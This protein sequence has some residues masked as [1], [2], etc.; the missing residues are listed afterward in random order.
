MLRWVTLA[1][2]TVALLMMSLLV[3]PT[4]ALLATVPA[5]IAGFR[6]TSFAALVA[7]ALLAVTVPA[8]A[9]QPTVTHGVLPE[10]PGMNGAPARAQDQLVLV[11]ALLAAALGALVVQRRQAEMGPMTV[12]RARRRGRRRCRPGHRRG[13]RRRAS[14]RLGPTADAVVGAAHVGPVRR[15]PLRS[16]PKLAHGRTSR[17]A[18]ALVALVALVVRADATTGFAWTVASA[19]IVVGLLFFRRRHHCFRRLR[20]PPPRA[21]STDDAVLDPGIPRGSM[22]FSTT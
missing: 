21:A 18:A 20:R 22:R 19:V 4:I 3:S 2:A 14:R 7:L 11:L 1:A 10:L 16:F 9:L 6:R 8:A 13:A 12:L 17:A 5:L 15:E